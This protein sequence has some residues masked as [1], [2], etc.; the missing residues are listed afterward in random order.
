MACLLSNEYWKLMTKSRKQSLW[1]SSW[2]LS[3]PGFCVC[4][5]P[6]PIVTT[7]QVLSMYNNIFMVS[8][9]AAFMVIYANWCFHADMHVACQREPFCIILSL[10][11][12]Y[13]WDLH[14]SHRQWEGK[15]WVNCSIGLVFQRQAYHKEMHNSQHKSVVGKWPD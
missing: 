13:W 1:P 4:F 15:G 3:K 9:T 5:Y 7:H 12:Q 2:R 11:H 14:H 10:W 6:N 8:R